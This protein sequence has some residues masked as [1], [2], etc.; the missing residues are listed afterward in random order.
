MKPNP[1]IQKLDAW[2]I[3]LNS[4]QF[5]SHGV[6]RSA[7]LEVLT[8]MATFSNSKERFWLFD[9]MKGC[10]RFGVLAFP[11]SRRI[12]DSGVRLMLDQLNAA[13]LSGCPTYDMVRE[14]PKNVAKRGY[15]EALL[16]DSPESGRWKQASSEPI[17]G[18]TQGERFAVT[19]RRP[20]HG[21]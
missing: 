2:C 17:K 21:G 13:I 6:Q 14:I 11:M 18:P 1:I 7:L 3:R 4:V 5:E 9:V 19:S 8:D 20:V 16:K 10:T 15:L 12:V